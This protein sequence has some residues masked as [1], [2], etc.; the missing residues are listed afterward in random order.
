MLTD[1]EELLV[2]SIRK[3]IGLPSADTLMCKTIPQSDIYKYLYN[4]D[5]DGVRGFT[6]VEEH[7]ANLKTL[8]DKYNGARLDYNNT[9]FKTTT[10][11]D[12]ISQSVGLPDKFY[13]TI[14]YKVNDVSKISIP[15]WAPK[16]DDYPY[17]GK[18]FTG[19]TD[20]VLPEYY[21]SVRKFINGDKFKILD[22]KTGDIVQQ[23]IYDKNLGWLELK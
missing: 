8:F 11:V 10:G 15:D 6:A 18:A 19:S 16:P 23:F 9:A 13:G 12:G 2:D 5:Y 21:Q 17:T 20:V 4:P 14:E 1:S 22:S 7:G 3:E